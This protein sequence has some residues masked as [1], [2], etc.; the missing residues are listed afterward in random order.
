M[1][2]K[3]VSIS[4]HAN[5]NEISILANPKRW[6]QFHKHTKEKTN[7]AQGQSL[8]G[9]V[10]PWKKSPWLKHGRRSESAPAIS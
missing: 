7:E 1:E 2:Q 10:I 8:A 5:S 3:V 9:Q 4:T 6:G